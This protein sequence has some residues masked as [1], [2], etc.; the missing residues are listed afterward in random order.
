MRPRRLALLCALALAI[1]AADALAAPMPLT[2]GGTAF[3]TGPPVAQANCD[4]GDAPC[5]LFEL[6][7]RES[8]GARLR[9]GIDHPRVGDTFTVD[10]TG[11]TGAAQTFGTE[12]GLYSAETTVTPRVGVWKVRVTATDA[13]DPRF[14]MRAKL[15][16]PSS[17]PPAQKVER[18]PNVQ[19]QPPYDFHFSFPLT[20]GG[21]ITAQQGDRPIGVPMP[22]GVLAC[23]PEEIAQGA[24][25]CLRMSF[26]VRN[27]GQGPMFFRHESEDPTAGD[28]TLYQLVYWS[29]GTHTERV[30]GIARYHPT[31]LHYHQD[32][33]VALQLFEVTDPVRGTSVPAGAEKRK[34]FHHREE[35][36]REWSHFYPLWKET[37][38]GLGSGWADYYEWDRPDNYLDFGSTATA[39]TSSA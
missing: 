11:P 33:A 7:V 9:V 6:E 37:G 31:H 2:L 12:S 19:I 28:Q 29:D 8:G 26:G 17:P 4:N 16:A 30:A 10:V 22:L 34:G 13:L 1:P 39:A 3:W 27:V 14:R 21:A 15:E 36:L 24:A 23:H 5:W 38:F 20:D 25:R 32:E 18:L 35:L